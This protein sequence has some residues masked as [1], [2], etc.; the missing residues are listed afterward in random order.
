MNALGFDAYGTLF[1]VF[2]VASLCEQL[3]PGQGH[4]LAQTWRR[5]QLEYSWLRSLMGRYRD[6]WGVTED[7]LVYSAKSLNLRLIPEARDQLMESYQH[8]AVFPDVE[9]GLRALKEGGLRL[10]ILSNGTPRMLHAAVESA[11]I[12]DLLDAIISV[13][14]VKK[15][16]PSPLV[17][18][19]LASALKMDQGKIGFVS[20]NNWDVNGAASA[21]LTAFW[22]RRSKEVPEELGYGATRVIEA[23]TDLPPLVSS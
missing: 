20:S 13:D 11:G 8:L 3:F 18:A 1:D 23:V 12:G 9:P 2:S 22:I 4:Q 21:G 14:A 16:K 7:A 19:Q 6:F 5:K 15:F 17:Y 10:A